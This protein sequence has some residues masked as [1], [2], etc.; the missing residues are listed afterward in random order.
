MM[1][2][3]SIYVVTSGTGWKVRCEHCK[4][5]LYTTQAAAISAAR[6]HVGALPQGTL[7]QILIQGANSQFRTEWTYGKDPFPPK[8]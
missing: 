5:G 8:G 3:K 1:N 6:K 7:S 4:E 2:R